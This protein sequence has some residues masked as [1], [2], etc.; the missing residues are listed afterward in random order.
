VIAST[1]E[2]LLLLLLLIIKVMSSVIHN[3]YDE[4]LS[5][6][7]GEC[8]EKVTLSERLIDEFLNACQHNCQMI[9]NSI[10]DMVNFG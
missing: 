8:I 7:Q 10:Y 6:Q 4:S 9:S 1:R 5:A 3:E 2:E